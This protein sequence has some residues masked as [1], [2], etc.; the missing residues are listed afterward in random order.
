L[1][2]CS[3]RVNQTASAAPPVRT[4]NKIAIASMADER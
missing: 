2:P 3:A 1:K 4:S